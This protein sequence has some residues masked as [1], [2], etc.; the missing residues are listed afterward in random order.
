MKYLRK[1]HFLFLLLFIIPHLYA[2][3]EQNINVLLLRSKFFENYLFIELY[4]QNRTSETIYVLKNYYI[5][6]IIENDEYLELSIKANA[7]NGL[8]GYDDNGE[9]EWISLS[10]FHEPSIVEIRSNQGSYLTLLLDISDKFIGM[11][12][13]NEIN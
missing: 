9:I 13:N 1:I 7:L 12:R 4:V 6:K 11:S 3:N 2:Q 8:I 5:E 10:M